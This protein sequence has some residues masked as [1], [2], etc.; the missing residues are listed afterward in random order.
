MGGMQRYGRSKDSIVVKP[1]RTKHGMTYGSRKTKIFICNTIEK[2]TPKRVIWQMPGKS[3][4]LGK[5]IYR[6]AQN[7]MKFSI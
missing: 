7:E 4:P 2:G 5:Q 1:I 6:E 3:N